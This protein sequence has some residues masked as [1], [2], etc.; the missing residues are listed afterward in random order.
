[1]ATLALIFEVLSRCEACTC[2]KP[3]INLT[4]ARL[5]S[6]KNDLAVMAT[7]SCSHNKPPTTHT[8]SAIVPARAAACSRP[9]AAARTHSSLHTQ[10]HAAA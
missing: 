5:R 7:Q 8:H 6:K 1:M 2:L 3:A 10:L 4:D 9:H